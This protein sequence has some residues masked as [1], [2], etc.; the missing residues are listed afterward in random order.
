MTVPLREK[1]KSLWGKHISGDFF[2]IIIYNIITF[3]STSLFPS[4]GLVQDIFI[5]GIE[6]AP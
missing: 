3:E 6:L 1:N 5:D 2:H 4:Y